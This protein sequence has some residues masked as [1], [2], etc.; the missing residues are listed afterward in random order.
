MKARIAVRI[1]ATVAAAASFL[2]GCMDSTVLN[3][4]K[5]A[6][7]GPAAPKSISVVI[8]SGQATI[9]WP[10]VAGADA[11]NLYWGPGSTVSTSSGTKVANAVSP[12][13]ITGLS[14]GTPYAFMVTTV[15]AY[16]ESAAGTGGSVTPGAAPAAPAISSRTPGARQVTI[17]WPTVVGAS[18]YNLYWKQGATAT[19]SDTK[20]T[21]VTSPYVLGSLADGTQYSFIVTAVDS[22]GESGTS[23]VRSATTNLY[24]LYATDG[25]TGLAALKMNSASG[26]LTAITGSPYTVLTDSKAVAVDPTGHYV[27]LANGQ[28][29]T[30]SGFAINQTSGALSAISGSSW[31]TMSYGDSTAVDPAGKFLYVSYYL[32]GG[33]DLAVYSITPGSGALTA[34]G[35]GTSLT[36]PSG[37]AVSQNGKFA[38]AVVNGNLGGNYLYGFTV[39]SGT[40]ALSGISGSPF[41]CGNT[42]EGIA[43]DPLSRFLYVTNYGSSTLH[44]YTIDGS[45]GVPT[46]VSGSFTTGGGYDRQAFDPAGKFLYITNNSGTSVT[47]YTINQTTGAPSQIGVY[48]TGSTPQGVAVDPTGT[49]VY[50][51]NTATNG[52]IS[53]F[54]INSSSGALAA[55][56]TFGTTSAY[57]SVAIATIVTP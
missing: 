31:S 43:V 17:N 26:A 22:F 18:S 24:V 34:V 3:A 30:I 1:L 16:R 56:S 36:G 51:A 32:S 52:G 13:T 55:V 11:Y 12:V 2:W 42:P 54:S 19:T 50:V 25:A 35:G 41:Y 6:E 10:S 7:A 9:S 57:N 4:L 15:N 53:I 40:G 45:T 5:A 38:Y 48:S 8:G 23:P 28:S 44:A 49:F 47:G 14:N 37:I 33:N 46:A 27:Y 39:D 20:V 29:S 21:G